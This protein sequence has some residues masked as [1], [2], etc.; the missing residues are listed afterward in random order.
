M[1]KIF[2]FDAHVAIF[3]PETIAAI[4]KIFAVIGSI[5]IA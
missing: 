3:S 5:A 2:T 4:Q 1:I